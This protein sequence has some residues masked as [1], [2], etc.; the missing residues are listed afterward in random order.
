MSNHLD[1]YVAYQMASAMCASIAQMIAEL[2]PSN[3]PYDTV[4][5]AVRVDEFT[6]YAKSMERAAE[7]EYMEMVD[8][9]VAA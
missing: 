3:D 5:D 6:D 7:F 1:R 8:A 9:A 2:P 4:R